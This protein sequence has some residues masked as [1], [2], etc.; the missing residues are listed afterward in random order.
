MSVVVEAEIKHSTAQ[1]KLALVLKIIQGQP[2]IAAVSRQSDLT[3]PEIESWVVDGKPRMENALKAWPENVD[4]Q[5]KRQLKDLQA[6]CRE[7][8][9]ELHGRKNL[10]SL[11]GNDQS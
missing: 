6:A 8:M 5:Y 1:R 11:L 4:E 3:P 7:A 2:T 9:L 10:A